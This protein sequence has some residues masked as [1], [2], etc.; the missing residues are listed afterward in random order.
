MTHHTVVPSAPV[1]FLD[2]V[3]DLSDLPRTR[4]TSSG[5][6]RQPSVTLCCGCHYPGLGY[7]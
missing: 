5:L 1:A 3:R 2:T 4:R 6:P 7:L